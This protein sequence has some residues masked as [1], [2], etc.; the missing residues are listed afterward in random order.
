VVPRYEC[1]VV[2]QPASGVPFSVLVD[3]IGE[4]VLAGQ[5]LVDRETA[6]PRVD[7]EEPIPDILA[8]LDALD[9]LV[10]R[11]VAHAR[12]VRRAGPARRQEVRSSP[13]WRVA[14]APGLTAWVTVSCRRTGAAPSRRPVSD[15]TVVRP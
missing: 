6:P 2:S 8:D 7:P 4:R 12:M 11:P 3:H 1:G 13:L 9:P 15:A 5:A 14:D 10:F